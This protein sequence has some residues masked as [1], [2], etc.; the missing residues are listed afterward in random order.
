[1]RSASCCE[2]SGAVVNA[3]FFNSIVGYGGAVIAST[4]S[5]HVAFACGHHYL[6]QQVL[7]AAAV[8]VVQQL[9]LPSSNF[10]DVDL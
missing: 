4:Y 7:E 2:G 6:P 1:M 5:I 9:H 3:G 10:G 8:D